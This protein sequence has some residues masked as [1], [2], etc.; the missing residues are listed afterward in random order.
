MR[1]PRVRRSRGA[2]ESLGAVVL[3]F[4]SIIVFLGG[5]VVFGLRAFPGSIPPWWGIVGGTVVALAMVVTAG[6]LRYRA[7]IVLGW[8]LQVVVVLGGFLVPALVLVGLIFGAMWAY[9]T[10]K[11]A[12]LDR[13]NASRAADAEPTNGD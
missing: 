5:L 7:G 2:A 12:A 11:G 13:R 9:A 8:A 6:L 4:E 1:E 10:I 3:G